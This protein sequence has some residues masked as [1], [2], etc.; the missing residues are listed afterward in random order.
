MTELK[1]HD[2]EADGTSV[3]LHITHNGHRYS[4]RILNVDVAEEFARDV[5]AACQNAR[6]ELVRQIHERTILERDYEHAAQEESAPD[7]VAMSAPQPSDAVAAEASSTSPVG[8]ADGP[9]GEASVAAPRVPSEQPD[10]APEPE[11]PKPKRAPRTDAQ[12]A[13]DAA[14]RRAATKEKK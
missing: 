3:V 10:P 5:L 7:T 11:T 9:V 2:A 8:I 4:P 14:R 12:K 1:Y 6:N 13:R